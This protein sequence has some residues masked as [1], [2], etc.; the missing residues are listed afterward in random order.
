MT[1]VERIRL[2]TQT[3]I[4]ATEWRETFEEA[5]KVTQAIIVLAEFNGT[6]AMSVTGKGRTLKGWQGDASL[7]REM[8]IEW[9]R[10]LEDKATTELKS[11]GV[12]L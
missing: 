5:D 2:L 3:V 11:M 8:A 9:M 12:D 7:P 4:D 10:W 6:E 1:R